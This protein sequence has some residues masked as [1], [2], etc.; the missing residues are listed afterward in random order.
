[1]QF[2]T[3]QKKP[4]NQTNSELGQ[5]HIYCTFK[6]IKTQ[7]AVL[8]KPFFHYLSFYQQVYVLKLNW[9]FSKR[10]FS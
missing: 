8:Q 5:K 9:T 10:V 6:K 4:K 3:I 2:S 7:N 1:M